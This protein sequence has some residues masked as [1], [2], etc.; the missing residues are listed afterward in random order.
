MNIYS[1]SLVRTYSNQGLMEPLNNTIPTIIMEDVQ[2]PP[3]PPPIP[4]TPTPPPPIPPPTPRIKVH[5]F[6]WIIVGLLLLVV[7]VFVR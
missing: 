4:P 3:S 2:H 5:H 6:D 7:L 1:P